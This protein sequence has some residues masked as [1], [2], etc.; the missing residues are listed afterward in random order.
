MANEQIDNP[1]LEHENEWPITNILKEL[2]ETFE[3]FESLIHRKIM[4][5][6]AQH[7]TVSTNEVD[8]LCN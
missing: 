7:G 8:A 3:K 1:L 4:R 2:E 6:K 5:S